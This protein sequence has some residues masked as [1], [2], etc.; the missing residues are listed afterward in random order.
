MDLYSVLCLSHLGLALLTAKIPVSCSSLAH[1]KGAV[2]LRAHAAAAAGYV[3]QQHSWE[4]LPNPQF[5][6]TAAGDSDWLLAGAAAL[7]QHIAALAP[8]FAAVRERPFFRFFAVDLLAS[9][10]YVPQNE[11]PCELD[12]CEIEPTEDVP[13]PMME[14]DANEYEFELDGWGRWDMPSDF[15]EYYDLHEH[16]EMNT[17]YDGSRVWRFIHQK[18]CFQLDLQEPEN[19]W[20]RD[21]NRGVSGLH[22]AVSASIVGDLLRTGDEEEARLQFRRRLRDEPGAVP[23]LYFATMLT[24]C[25]IQRVA[26]RLGRCTYLGDVQQV[27]PPMEQILDSPA[28]AEPSLSRAAAL[29]REHADSEEAAPWK[30]RLRTRDLLGVMN[31]VQCNLCR[32]HGKVT[33]AGFAAALQVLLGYRGRG[34]H[35]DKEADPYSLN[36]VE[37]AALVVTGGKLVA[38]CHTVETLQAL[39]A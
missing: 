33:V 4:S 9:C 29:L 12:A 5:D 16:A 2:A 39:E 34:D 18:I 1:G 17:G 10:G 36:R 19:S 28:L 22:S 38:A 27:W 26:P 30:I 25:A 6:Y 37:V 8:Q 11:V 3:P 14:R 24:L 15:T 23:N 21:F 31:C 13:P 32:L 20:K 35:C 7:S